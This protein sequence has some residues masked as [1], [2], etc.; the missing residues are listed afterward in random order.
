M[1]N[2]SVSPCIPQKN[3][4]VN[5][6]EIQCIQPASPCQ[7]PSY[8]CL[9]L[10]LT[11]ERMRSLLP[12]SKTS[13]CQAGPTLSPLPFPRFARWPVLPTQLNQALCLLWH[14][15]LMW[16][17]WHPWELSRSCWR[18]WAVCSRSVRKKQKMLGME[19]KVS[20]SWLGVTWPSTV[21]GPFTLAVQCVC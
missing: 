8:F 9:V 10:C 5:V 16:R 7:R 6:L 11:T 4:K 15:K 1:T 3:V 14:L 2:L 17:L 12:A 21:S 19:E 20:H 13:R 18:R